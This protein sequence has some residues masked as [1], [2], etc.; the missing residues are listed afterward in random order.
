M[1]THLFTFLALIRTQSEKFRL[2]V[3]WKRLSPCIEATPN[4]V[5]E[6]R[7]GSE[8]MIHTLGYRFH[9][10]EGNGKPVLVHLVLRDLWTEHSCKESLKCLVRFNYL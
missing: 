1:E 4:P 8:L 10:I 7:T 5:C 6:D 9:L 2:Q 3:E